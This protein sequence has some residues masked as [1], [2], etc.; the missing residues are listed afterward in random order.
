MKDI[1][2]LCHGVFDLFHVGHLSHLNAARK[3][4]DRLVV[5]VLAD[6]FVVKNRPIYDEK[7][8]MQLIG[9]LRCVDQVILC[10]APGPQYIIERLKPDVYVRG[11]DYRGKRMPES[12]L[13]E[14]MGIPVRYTKSVPPRTS[15]IIQKIRGQ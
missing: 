1:I 10:K 11:T 7:A 4:G 8:R 12:N 13:L 15:E 14:E 9:D 2:V 6:N 5:S 3:F